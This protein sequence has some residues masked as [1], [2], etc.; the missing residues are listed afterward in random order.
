M[1]AVVNV[2]EDYSRVGLQQYEVRLN[3]I[4]LAS[5]DHMAEEGMPECLRKAAE[6][7]EALGE[8]GIDQKIKEYDERREGILLELMELDRQT[9]GV[10]W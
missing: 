7:V 10:V 3:N 1:I 5:F 4:V 2:S 6:S 8:G 9:R